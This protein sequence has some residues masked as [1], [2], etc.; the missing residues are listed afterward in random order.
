VP[1]HFRIVVEITDAITGT[2]ETALL[3]ALTAEPALRAR[4]VAG[5]EDAAGAADVRLVSA[6]IVAV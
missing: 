6:P 3:A 4:L 5:V 2:M 1:K